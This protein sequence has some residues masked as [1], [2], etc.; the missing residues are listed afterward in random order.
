[1]SRVENGDEGV[2]GRKETEN[3]FP[4]KASL[5]CPLDKPMFFTYLPLLIFD[6]LRP[7]CSNVQHYLVLF[8]RGALNVYRKVCKFQRRLAGK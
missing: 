5:N 1:M 6:C 7:P 8:S 2:A 4:S 3:S